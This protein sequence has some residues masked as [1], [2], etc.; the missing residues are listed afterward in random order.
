MIVGDNIDK[1]VRPSYQHQG[2][3]TQSLHYFHSY[4][5]L[6]RLD[7]SGLSDSRSSHITISPEKII[8]DFSEHQKLLGDFET[9]VTRYVCISVC[10]HLSMILVEHM[11]EFKA[12]KCEVQWHVKS[13]YSEEMA[14]KSRVAC[15]AIEYPVYSCLCCLSII[16]KFFCL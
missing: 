3:T 4:A 2:R 11:D 10:L 12:Q 9:L 14:S 15:V 7:T 5:V 1:N 8:P 13:D 16:K 6:N